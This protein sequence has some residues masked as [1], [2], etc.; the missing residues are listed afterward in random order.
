MSCS[1][2]RSFCQSV[3]L[4][5]SSSR[6]SPESH[7]ICLVTSSHP[8]GPFL[9]P[10]RTLE[11]YHATPHRITDTR[12]PR[13]RHYLDRHLSRQDLIFREQERERRTRRIRR[14]KKERRNNNSRE[15]E[16]RRQ[17]VYIYRLISP[18][19]KHN[20][21]KQTQKCPPSSRPRTWP[22]P[23]APSGKSPSR[24]RRRTSPS[25][26]RCR[27]PRPAS[28]TR[29]GGTRR[30]SSSSP[31][32]TPATR[33][34]TAPSGPR[35]PSRS[36][37]ATSS[38]VCLLLFSVFLC[39][40]KTFMHYSALL[41][42][43]LITP[44]PTPLVYLHTTPPLLSS[45]LLSLFLSPHTQF[46][47]SSPS[48]LAFLLTEEAT[49]RPGEPDKRTSR[50]LG[51]VPGPAVHTGGVPGPAQPGMRDLVHMSTP[52]LPDKPRGQFI[53]MRALYLA[54]TN[55]DSLLLSAFSLLPQIA[56]S[57]T[58]RRTSSSRPSNTSD[59]TT[60]GTWSGCARTPR[61][62]SGGR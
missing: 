22:R 30:S 62:A 47:S 50:V 3:L 49:T 43:T 19:E 2:A 32:T 53:T 44:P 21:T 34:C 16:P 9:V 29:A 25:R 57:T 15:K 46:A 55:A 28:R 40:R 61:C 54:H 18:G 1:P 7:F 4:L 58:T 20:Q 26:R 56:Y 33:R 48:R 12:S 24:R 13:H 37:T 51:S 11:T 27:R 60:P 39:T 36:R 6:S 5:S 14:K 38:I 8:S 31:S 35:W 59:T 45:P 10:S 52:I 17:E 42:P 23:A 41:P